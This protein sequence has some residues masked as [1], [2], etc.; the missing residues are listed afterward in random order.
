VPKIYHNYFTENYNI[1]DYDTRNKN[2]FHLSTVN[3]CYGSRAIT[4]KGCNL[5]NQL[6]EDVKN[7]QNITTFR[8]KLKEL[9]YNG[10]SLC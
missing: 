6:P 8:N 5:W 9:F 4:F 1:Y 3:L 2:N 7:A 10:M